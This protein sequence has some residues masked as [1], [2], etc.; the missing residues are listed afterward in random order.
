MRNKVFIFSTVSILLTLVIFTELIS[1]GIINLED[2]N[3]GKKMSDEKF[4]VVKSEEEWKKTLTPEQ[5]EVLRQKGTERP[6]TGK[7]NIHTAKGK[8]TCAGCGNELFASN[9]KFDSHCGWPSF[10]DIIDSSKVLEIVD[11]SHG[12]VRT[13]VVCKK[14]GGH[15]GHL[16]NDGPKPTSNRYCI[17]SVS[18][19]FLPE[20]STQAK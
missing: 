6:F 13:E 15:L 14:C 5:Y 19:E 3:E 9:T 17:N 1:S 12:M 18:I 20:D 4:E 8:Y 16:F 7:Y 2:K 10:Y 11:R